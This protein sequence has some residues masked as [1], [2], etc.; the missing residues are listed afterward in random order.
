MPRLQ[1]DGVTLN[2]PSAVAIIGRYTDG[3]GEC[4][5]PTADQDFHLG[6]PGYNEVI[7]TTH[8]GMADLSEA[9]YRKKKESSHINTGSFSTPQFDI[10]PTA[11]YDRIP[12]WVSP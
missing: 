2:A 9:H 1:R 11:G 12:G 10:S 6:I 3:L 4:R 8:G 7:T 5:G